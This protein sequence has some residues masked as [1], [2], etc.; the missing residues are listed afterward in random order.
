M[1]NNMDEATSKMQNIN[2]NAQASPT[3]TM[4][5]DNR[6]SADRSI[7]TSVVAGVGQQPGGGFS[8]ISQASQP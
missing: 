8:V 5:R 7:S 2:L 3:R 6:V 4:E 1:L